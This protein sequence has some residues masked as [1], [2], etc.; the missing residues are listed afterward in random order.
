M[1]QVQVFHIGTDCTLAVSCV[2]HFDGGVDIFTEECLRAASK[3]V[4]HK[5]SIAGCAVSDT[6]KGTQIQPV[7]VSEWQGKTMDIFPGGS[8]SQWCDH[9][10]WSEA[11]KG[12]DVREAMAR[13]VVSPPVPPHTPTL[14]ASTSASV[15]L[16]L[17]VHHVATDARGLMQLLRDLLLAA[18]DRGVQGGVSHDAPVPP[19]L[20]DWMPRMK[21]ALDLQG[22]AGPTGQP[23][24][25]AFPKLLPPC[26]PPPIQSFS[27]AGAAATGSAGVSS[28]QKALP[29]G[30][31]PP[32]STRCFGAGPPW[33]AAA[34]NSEVERAAVPAA[35]TAPWGGGGSLEPEPTAK[36][37]YQPPK[38][39]H[40]Q[41]TT[42][43]VLSEE[44]TAL[45]LGAAKQAGVG[46]WAWVQ[47]ASLL[48]EAS[49]AAECKG[50]GGELTWPVRARTFV[51][52]RGLVAPP[53]PQDFVGPITGVASLETMTVT[54]STS[55]AELALQLQHGLQD[56]VQSLDVLRTVQTLL[57]GGAASLAVNNYGHLQQLEL[58]ADCG[59]RMTDVWV[60]RQERTSPAAHEQFNIV[61]FS[62]NRQL[63][64]SI[65]F[66]PAVWHE[67]CVSLFLERTIQ[68]ALHAAM[69]TSG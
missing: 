2:L 50:G 10:A 44:H 36:G 40:V 14:G 17:L 8:L 58:P 5:H 33:A 63:H 43:L 3:S 67:Q 4:I 41:F 7:M 9:V 37:C 28:T 19:S 21:A 31:D 49:F 47:A 62:V 61:V 45:V 66:M 11:A 64:L 65:S 15:G 12:V 60:I 1:N 29:H 34:E 39:V 27:A 20:V 57:F 51:D 22:H 25:P 68:A 26:I 24:P 46:V 13:F 69:A 16:V 53:L 6:V 32:S 55:V 18:V 59:V 42:R 48:V 52:A 56:A 38:L 23:I 30:E 35:H 54:P